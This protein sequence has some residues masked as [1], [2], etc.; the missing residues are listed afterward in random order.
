MNNY[1]K[2]ISALAVFSLCLFSCQNR[3]E[4]SSEATLFAQVTQTDGKSVKVFLSAASQED[5][6]VEQQEITF[7][8]DLVT[9]FLL[10]NVYPEFQYQ[11]V[12]GFGAAFTETS[13][14]NF[15]KLSAE[16]QRELTELYFGE[17]GI[18]LN[19]CRTHINSCDFSLTEYTY[20][21]EGD[22]ELKTFSIDRERMY[23]L[24]MM[25]MAL[26]VNPDIL[27]MASPWT[28]P[29]WMKD[30]NRLTRG[31]RLLR[32]HY[33]TW[34]NYFTRY[35]EEYKKEGVDFFG[36]SVQNEP[37]AVQSWESCIWTGEEEGVFA[38]NYLRPTF[39][40]NGFGDT[41][42]MIWDHN[43]ERVMDRARE[44]MSVPGAGE[45]V[46]GIGFHWYSGDHF[47]NLR[48]AHELFPDKPLIATEN[49]F[50]VEKY[51]GRMHW[52]TVERYA[53]ETIMNF[54]NFMSAALAW[55]L[56]VDLHTGGPVNNRAVGSTAPV[57]VDATK[58]EYILGPVYY[59]KGH[60]SKFVKRG[61]VRIGTS[62]Y[63]DA[64]KVTAFINPCGEVIVVILNMG[65]RDAA[66]K[67]RMNDCTADFV[68]PAKSLITMVVPR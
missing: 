64:I 67:I 46:W 21:D 6:L 2:Q 53:K 1:T 19:F 11:T 34:A 25:K 59:T 57:Y 41:K 12:L 5:M 26:E 65:D 27:L 61:A 36:V 4:T 28:P 22:V 7:R 62:S 40:R 33:Q 60:F 50:G 14:Y 35:I 54:N 18:G 8:E 44:T 13:G 58:G 10:I 43:K 52:G 39:D 9:E 20:V 23:I 48:M 63:S 68:L 47:D 38:A 32:E 56:I 15:S 24:P 3:Q 30:N 45:A 31:G 55:N 42:I 37:M 51:E 49:S 17:N 66:P 16:L 29:A